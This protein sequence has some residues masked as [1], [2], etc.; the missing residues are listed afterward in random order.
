MRNCQPEGFGRRLIDMCA[1]VYFTGGSLN[2]VRSFGC[3]VA[4]LSFPSY[5]WIYWLGPTLGSLVAAGYFRFAKL[6]HYEEANPG[7][8][9][10]EP[11]PEPRV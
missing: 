5:H 1:G 6:C 8:D 2:P 10:S 7:Q 9:E 11:E 4:A 3:A